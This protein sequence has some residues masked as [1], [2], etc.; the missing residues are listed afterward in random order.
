ML[1]TG[2]SNPTQV[3]KQKIIL[4]DDH[5]II[6]HGIRTT[7]TGSNWDVCAE[8]SNGKEAIEAIRKFDPDVVL[9]DVSMPI[10]NGF[11]T[12]RL[13]REIGL[14]TRIVM[15][16]VHE[17]AGFIR[18]ARNVGAVGYVLKSRSSGD[19]VK[20]IESVLSGDTFFPQPL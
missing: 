1:T 14:R 6:R 2:L 15:F 18:E 10:M 4:V 17:S 13:V 19:L 7:L 5:Q 16:S 12:A 8:A 3:A 20:A 11:E 9:L